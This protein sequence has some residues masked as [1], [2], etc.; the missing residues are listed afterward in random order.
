[1]LLIN[2]KKKEEETEKKGEKKEKRKKRR[3][4]VVAIAGKC[5]PN[6]HL[7][8]N[9]EFDVIITAIK[10]LKQSKIRST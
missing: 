8:L 9:V 7:R 2:G 6:P 1:M 5:F 3:G 4:E 10:E